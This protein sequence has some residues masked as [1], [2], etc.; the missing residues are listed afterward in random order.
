MDYEPTVDEEEVEKR[1]PLS[2]AV[3]EWYDPVDEVFNEIRN[4]LD[5]ERIIN[6]ELQLD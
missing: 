4:S 3:Q 2:Q 5:R 6:Q 1:V